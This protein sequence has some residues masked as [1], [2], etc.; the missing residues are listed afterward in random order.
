MPFL[1]KISFLNLYLSDVFSNNLIA[2]LQ[3]IFSIHHSN[4]ILWKTNEKFFPVAATS[5][6][7]DNPLVLLQ[8]VSSVWC[9]SRSDVINRQ[10]RLVFQTRDLFPSNVTRAGL[11]VRLVRL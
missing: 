3:N 7:S 8:L 2:N 9:T 6:Q 10:T 5:I 1:I 4:L 11:P